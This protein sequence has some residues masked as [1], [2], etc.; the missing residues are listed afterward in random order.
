MRSSHRLFDGGEGATLR[1]RQVTRFCKRE[2][3]AG[4]MRTSTL[5]M[6]DTH[7]LSGHHAIAV[8][9]CRIVQNGI[10]LIYFIAAW[11][12]RIAE[13]HVN[14]LDIVD[15]AI[16][17]RDSSRGHIR[18]PSCSD[19]QVR[20]LRFHSPKTTMTAVARR[21]GGMVKP[22]VRRM[23]MWRRNHRP[24]ETVRIASAKER[25]EKARLGWGTKSSKTKKEPDHDKGHGS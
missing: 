23:K 18:P 22:L 25:V 9:Q 20:D 17:A 19:W 10:R 11:T 3:L 12:V 2:K 13:L 5:A 15:E 24:T 1:G 21:R 14:P 7:A 16:A 4:L 6:K 8:T